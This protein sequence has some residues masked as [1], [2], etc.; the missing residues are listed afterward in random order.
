MGT[1]NIY[2]AKSYTEPY[3]GS[4][5]YLFI[6]NYLPRQQLRSLAAV[7]LCTVLIQNWE[8]YIQYVITITWENENMHKHYAISTTSIRA[9]THKVY[10]QYAST[11]TSQYMY[12]HTPRPTN[13]NMYKTR[14]NRNYITVEKHKIQYNL[15]ISTIHCGCFPPL[16]PPP[17][18]RKKK[19]KN[20][21]DKT[22]HYSLPKRSASLRKQ[23]RP[24]TSQPSP[25]TLS[26][27]YGGLKCRALLAASAAQSTNTWA[28]VNGSPQSSHRERASP[29][30]NHPWV[31]LV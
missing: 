8:S 4:C 7:T 10:I 31:N 26:R 29:A 25:S 5:I 6:G 21:T 11:G 12:L 13:G 19:K 9:R 1:N 2:K 3:C 17:K 14:T 28:T 30:I 23:T 18:K 24:T 20:P 15:L 22:N 27:V 16:P